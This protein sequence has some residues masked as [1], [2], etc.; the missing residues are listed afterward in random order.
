ML[1]HQQPSCLCP[2]PGAQS[3]SIMAKGNN[4]KM[5]NGSALQFE[6]QLWTAAEQAVPAPH[7]KIPEYNSARPEGLSDPKSEWFI[8]DEPGRTEA[9]ENRDEYLAANVFWLPPEA[10]WHT[11]KAKA[12]SPEIPPAG[13]N[14][15][16]CCESGAAVDRGGGVGVGGVRQPCPFFA[17]ATIYPTESIHRPTRMNC[18]FIIQPLAFSLGMSNIRQFIL[19]QAFE[20]KLTGTNSN[21]RKTG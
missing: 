13:R 8:E 2:F 16:D 15:T 10:R 19:Q 21:A 5:A 18:T 7:L 17:V 4:Q 9:A 6:A 20:G 1:N 3:P 11:I 14:D 12:K